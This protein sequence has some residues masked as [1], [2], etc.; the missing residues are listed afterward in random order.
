[1]TGHLVPTSFNVAAVEHW[2]WAQIW[3]EPEEAAKQPGKASTL[4]TGH[5]AGE[6]LLLHCHLTLAE[7]GLAASSS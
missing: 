1:M 7:F 5:A 3:P 6:R 2:S 4:C